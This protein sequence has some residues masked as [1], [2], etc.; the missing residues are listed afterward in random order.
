MWRNMTRLLL[1]CMLDIVQRLWLQLVMEEQRFATVMWG[2][3]DFIADAGGSDPARREWLMECSGLQVNLRQA[4]S[5]QTCFCQSCCTLQCCYY[6]NC[7]IPSQEK[8][9]GSLRTN[10]CTK[11]HSQAA[12]NSD[13][14]SAHV[15]PLYLRS[16]WDLC[17]VLAATDNS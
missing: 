2:G 12:A 8:V 5:T 4:F 15:L 14:Q 7:H 9:C 10:W 16:G 17:W 6:I 13:G 11:S 1:L 3:F